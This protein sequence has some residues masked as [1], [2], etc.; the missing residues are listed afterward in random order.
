MN[1]RNEAAETTWLRGQLRQLV[2]ACG[3]DLAEPARTIKS[4]LGL[5]ERR[6]G[7]SLTPEALEFM[8]FAVDAAARL[9]TMLEALLELGRIGTEPAPVEPVP[10]GPAAEAATASL[11]P[12]LDAAGAEVTV[13]ELPALPGDRK[14][15][16]RLF[17]ILVENALRYRGDAPPLIRIDAA[18]GRI[19]VADNGVGIDPRFHARIFEPFQRLHTRDDIPGCGMGLTI[20]R[21][22]AEHHGCSLM[23][24][25]GPS[26]GSVLVLALDA[27]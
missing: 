21:R 26:G 25:A 15:W 6:H 9:E 16:R 5:I 14:L 12:E 27:S 17:A 18:P 8:G 10:L 22:I 3:H 11:R 20:A 19:T 7:E 4:F 24:E 13:G 1:T 23:V 2:H